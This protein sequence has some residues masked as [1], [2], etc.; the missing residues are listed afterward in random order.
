MRH[1]R[2]TSSSAW[3]TFMPTMRRKAF[4]QLSQ[5]AKAREAEAC[6]SLAHSLKSM[7]LN[8]GAIK[9]AKIAADF[10]QMAKGT[11]RFPIR[12]RSTRCRAR[13]SGLWRPWL[14]K[15]REKAAGHWSRRPTATRPE[16]PG[17]QHQRDLHLAIEREELDVEYQPF[18]D[19]AGKQVLG[20]E[21]LV[22]WRRGGVDNVSPSVFVPIAEGNWI[23]CSR[24]GRMGVAPSLQGRVGLAQAHGRRER[25]ANSISPAWARASH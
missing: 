18:V 25:V 7:S 15:W 23:H 13:W 17:R 1:R 12:T 22:R 5:H 19:R 11:A 6:G 21:A 10:E 4:S 14:A 2:V 3:L 20:V 24:Y 16:R 9:V 8:I